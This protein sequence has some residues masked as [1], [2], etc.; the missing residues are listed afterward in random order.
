MT[1]GDGRPWLPAV[2][3]LLQVPGCWSL[4]GPTSVTG[5]VGGSLSVQ[6]QYE[7]KFKENVKYWCKTPCLGDIVKTQ[8]ADKEVRSGRVSIRDRPANLTFTVTLENLT[9]GD[10]GTYRCGIDTSW[11]PEYL[12]DLTFRVVVS[13]IPGSLSLSGPSTVTGTVGGSLNVRCQYEEKYKTFT[14]YWCR[15]PCLPPWNQT[16]ATGRSEEKMRS[17]RV[18]IVD[19]AEDLTFTVTLE[20]LTADDAG[21]YRCGIATILQDKGLHGFLP[22]LFFQVQVLVSSR[23]QVVSIHF[24]LLIFLKVPLFLMMLSAVLWVNRPQWAICG[25]QSR[26]EEDNLEPSLSV[27]IL[28]L[29]SRVHF[30]LLVILKVSLLLTMLTDGLGL[31]PIG[32]IP[33]PVLP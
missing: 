26:P 13:V 32:A 19:H 16:V 6:C 4:R 25:T 29:F 14:K 33:Q 9:E 17:G 28:S 2:L 11:L 31:L 7:E 24:L 22:D 8:E 27:N 10:A 12:L 20:N 21:K 15:Q 5:P 30:L 1:P 18:S 3:L 23:S